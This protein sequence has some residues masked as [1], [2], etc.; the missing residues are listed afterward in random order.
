MGLLSNQYCVF[1]FFYRGSLS[2][3]PFPV[4]FKLWLHRDDVKQ[5]PADDGVLWCLLHHTGGTSSCFSMFP[6][7]VI[8][9]SCAPQLLLYLCQNGSYVL[10]MLWW[11][12]PL[13]LACP[14]KMATPAP[15]YS[16]SVFCSTTG[17]VVQIKGQEQDI[18][19]LGVI[20]IFQFF[21]DIDLFLITTN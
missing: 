6:P 8:S 1:F 13:K 11:G 16:P 15:S 5:Q 10:P 2:H 20:G 7:A 4:T 19:M 14:V 17:M 9:V 21:S 3:L 18:A 12:S